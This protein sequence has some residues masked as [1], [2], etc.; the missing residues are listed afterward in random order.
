MLVGRIDARDIC[1]LCAGVDLRF[2]CRSCGED[3]K[4]Y[5]DG[6]CRRCVVVGKVNDLL[7]GPGEAI[8][9]HLKPLA[10]VLTSVYPSTA[11]KWLGSES[12]APLLRDLPTRTTEISHEDL[13]QLSQQTDI[14]HL[15]ELLVAAGMLPRRNENLAQMQLWATRTVSALPPHQQ[16]ILRPFVE[17][18]ILRRVR[19][20]LRRRG[21]RR[22]AAMSDR[23]RIKVAIE[24]LAWLDTSGITIEAL[25]Q[26]HL[27]T[28]LDANPS[29]RARIIGFLTWLNEHRLIADIEIPRRKYGLPQQFQDIDDYDRQLRRCLTDDTLPLELRIVGALVRLYALPLVRIVELTIDRFSRDDIGAY[30]TIDQNPIVL[31]PALADLIEQRIN[32]LQSEATFSGHAVP[33]MTYLLPGKPPSRPINVPG[34]ARALN[35]RE[36]PTIAA[37]NSAMMANIAD[38]DPVVVSDL[39]GVHPATAHKWAHY[40]QSS[41]AIYLASLAR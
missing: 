6:E 11:L 36:L 10:A 19:R 31:P 1:A 4:N 37:R 18:H 5:V 21:Y 35:R 13:D 3:G 2:A 40:A 38:L 14:H 16:K 39:F 8:A 28:W 25:T 29:R 17:W 15:R 20:R 34:L 33:S 7:K 22:G 12:L 9:P 32:Q 41:W 23:S 26:P 30:L 24:F 27:D